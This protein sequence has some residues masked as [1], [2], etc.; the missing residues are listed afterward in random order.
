M[1]VD[2]IDSGVGISSDN[3]KK[4]FKIFGKLAATASMN[5]QGVGL[6]LIIC[7]NICEKLDGWI[8]VDSQPNSG[9]TFSFCILLEDWK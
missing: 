2:V 8:K 5:T 3:Q 1:I 6:G 4:L 9:A 7:K